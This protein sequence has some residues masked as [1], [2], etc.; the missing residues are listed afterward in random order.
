[1]LE[2]HSPSGVTPQ[3][4]IFHSWLHG[5]TF[6]KSIKLRGKTW[7]ANSVF[8]ANNVNESF[9]TE[10]NSKTLVSL[11]TFYEN[12]SPDVMHSHGK[13]AVVG[14]IFANNVGVNKTHGSGGTLR[15]KRSYLDREASGVITVENELEASPSLHCPAGGC[16]WDGMPDTNDGPKSFSPTV[17]NYGDAYQITLQELANF[18]LAADM[19]PAVCG[20]TIAPP[21][22]EC[23]AALLGDPTDF[24]GD[25][26]PAYDDS[27]AKVTPGAVEMNSAT[28]GGESND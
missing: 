25:G 15:F 12:G 23:L 17:E 2:I 16:K 26:R 19:L 10:G 6:E 9:R 4:Q 14:T 20:G 22:A 28:T 3:N 27:N 21:S 18:A 24:H 7:V 13:D 1:L 11:S 5:A 8:S